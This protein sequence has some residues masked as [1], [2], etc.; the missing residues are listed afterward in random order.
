M[1]FREI[2]FPLCDGAAVLRPA[3][4]SSPCLW[5]QDE[6]ASLRRTLM[7]RLSAGGLSDGLLGALQFGFSGLVLFPFMR[8]PC[9]NFSILRFL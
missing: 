8:G 5:G 2:V 9:V 7:V 3:L 6:L 4:L 1:A